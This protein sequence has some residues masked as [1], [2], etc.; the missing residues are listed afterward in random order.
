M[1][2]AI[3]RRAPA[4]SR[5]RLLEIVTPRTNPLPIAAA[6]HFLSALALAEPFSLELAATH[7]ARWLL[8]RTESEAME[9]HTHDQL[10]AAYAQSDLR[11]IDVDT[12]PSLD[13]ALVRPDEQTG[14]CVML[15]RAPGYLP[16][17]TFADAD[18][19]GAAWP[20][21]MASLLAALGSVPSGWRAL[22]QLVLR[23]APFDW[24]K[25]YQRLAI[26]HALAPEQRLEHVSSSSPDIVHLFAA[27]CAV[28]VVGGFGYSLVQAGAWLPLVGLSVG[29][30]GAGGGL[31]TLKRK[32]GRRE[33]YDM[34][35]VQQKIEHSAYVAEPRLSVFAPASAGSAQ[36][37]SQLKRIA[38][39]YGHFNL[40]SG[41]GLAPRDVDAS[42]ARLSSTAPMV[43]ARKLP[44]LNVRELAGLW[45]P[46]SDGAGVPLLERT[47]ARRYLPLPAALSRGRQLGWSCHH[48]HNLPVLVGD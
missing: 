26:E 21:P 47:S 35:L 20:D 16:L 29:G 33:L 32:L 36:L 30:A 10:A 25:G 43:T 1:R 34:R 31:L 46:P 37:N 15:L 18:A 13:P 19:S 27:L 14:T 42:G 6:E 8:V 44:V 3:E 45:H 41:N 11:P 2:L 40:A 5:P 28:G 39:A 38:A 12:F 7:E 24:C 23:P 22:S 17:R 48:G 4:V 9:R